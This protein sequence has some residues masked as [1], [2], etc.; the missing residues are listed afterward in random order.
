MGLFFTS[1]RLWVNIHPRRIFLLFKPWMFVEIIL[2][3]GEVVGA[4]ERGQS[5]TMVIMLH[6]SKYR[7]LATRDKNLLGYLFLKCRPLHST[8]YVRVFSCA[9]IT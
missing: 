5:N 3:Y 6:T 2:L 9:S 1:I 7:R 8:A 4:E